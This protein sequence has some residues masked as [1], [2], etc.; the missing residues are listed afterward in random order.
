M[1]LTI[2]RPGETSPNDGYGQGG[3][4]E[5]RWWEESKGEVCGRHELEGREVTRGRDIP[6]ETGGF[7]ASEVRAHQLLSTT[8]EGV[9]RLHHQPC[10]QARGR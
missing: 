7:L 6:F 3:V 5:R 1:H 4:P 9:H 8:T 10:H 2:C